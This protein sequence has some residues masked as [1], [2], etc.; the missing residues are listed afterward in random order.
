LEIS[1]KGEIIGNEEARLIAPRFD[2]FLLAGGF[3]PSF[4]G[5]AIGAAVFLAILVS[6]TALLVYAL[7]RPGRWIVVPLL[8]S[9]VIVLIGFALESDPGDAGG[10][11]GA[12]LPPPPYVVRDEAAVEAAV[13]EQHPRYPVGLG[14][15]RGRFTGNCVDTA[16][17]SG[18]YACL[19]RDENVRGFACIG[20]NLIVL[21]GRFGNRHFVDGEGRRLP[22]SQLC[23]PRT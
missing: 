15:W 2:H 19:Y 21:S 9:G 20:S 7:V 12:P 1:G 3:A 10:A 22:H 23:L 5:L 11:A 16:G 17:F 18:R 4:D 8:A 14:S 13:A 6:G